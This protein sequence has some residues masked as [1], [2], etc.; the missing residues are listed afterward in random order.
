MVV[1]PVPVT[2]L[3]PVAVMVVIPV[4][5]TVL[6]PVAVMVVIPVPVT[7]LVA[8]MVVIPVPVLVPVTV[9]VA[10]VVVVSVPVT[11]WLALVASLGADAQILGQYLLHRV[12]LEMLARGFPGLAVA[13][14]H[15]GL[16]SQLPDGCMA[17]DHAGQCPAEALHVVVDVVEAPPH[18]PQMASRDE[19]GRVK[20]GRLPRAIRGRL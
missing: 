3:V 6:V 12:V 8:V 15:C 5:V 4:P 2:V 20:L 9:L 7:V 10:V 14:V 11:I 16:A 13:L 18:V 19:H 1:I 17:F